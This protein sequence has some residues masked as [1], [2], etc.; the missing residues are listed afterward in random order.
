MNQEPRDIFPQSDVIIERREDPGEGGIRFVF[1]TGP[2]A[3]N[4]TK[5]AS[6][7]AYKGKV[8]LRVY[9][10]PQAHEQGLIALD[11]AQAFAISSRLDTAARLVMEQGK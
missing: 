5:F 10:P 1:S 7:A 4:A 6:V 9:A 8:Y 3:D 11:A 2:N